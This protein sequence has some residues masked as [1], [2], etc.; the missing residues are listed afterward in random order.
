MSTIFNRYWDSKERLIFLGSELGLADTVNIVYEKFEELTLKARSQFWIETEIPLENDKKQWPT[1]PEHIQRK[2][3]LN[4]GWQTMADSFIARAPEN[5]FKKLVSRPELADMMTQW[6]YFENIHSRAYANIIR[7]V[8][9]NPG[10]FIDS[11]KDNEEAFARI[12]MP[13]EILDELAS[14]GDYWIFVR[15]NPQDYPEGELERVTEEVQLLL[16]KA[17]YAVYGLEAM[18]F[19]SSFACTFALAENDILSGIAKNLQLIAKD[20]ALHTVMAKEIINVLSQQF[21]E[22]IIKEAREAAPMLLRAILK[23]EINWGHFIFPAGDPGLIG[24]N[25]ELLEE[26][27]YFIARNAFLNIGVEWP[28]DL[29]VITK[30]PI[31]WINNWLD[32]S[33]QQVAPQEMSIINYR[34]GQTSKASDE[35]ISNLGQ[36]FNF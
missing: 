2:T 14:T 8:L 27:L 28:S 11:V 23:T 26:Y 9:P 7:N 22:H 15:D 13:I 30:N 1:L 19:Y 5:V 32:T 24:L 17:Y 35:D 25:A 31:P 16:L 33:N 21:P 3:K 36:E 12:A 10:E 34:V 18:M 20:E 6:A 29:P 4:L